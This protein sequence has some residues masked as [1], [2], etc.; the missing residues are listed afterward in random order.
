LFTGIGWENSETPDRADFRPSGATHL[1]WAYELSQPQLP[2]TD[3]FKHL[4][5]LADKIIGKHRTD[6]APGT[7]QVSVNGH[8]SAIYGESSRS[9]SRKHEG[10][11]S[12]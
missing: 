1:P 11:S 4:R 5:K 12:G 9:F 2:P 6:P 3:T 10:K 8:L 7:S